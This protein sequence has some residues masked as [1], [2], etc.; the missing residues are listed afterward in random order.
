M[1]STNLKTA[2]IALLCYLIWSMTWWTLL[3]LK[4][5]NLSWIVNFLILPKQLKELLTLW[6]TL[7]SKKI[8]PLTSLLIKILNLF[9]KT[10]K[11]MKTDFLKYFWI[12]SQMRLSLHLKMGQYGCKFARM[13]IK[14]FAKKYF[15]QKI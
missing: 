5:W 10:L 11:V 7:K 12:F 8:L 1:S 6:A 14:S 3:N 15:L 13:E 2:N 9:S 4:K